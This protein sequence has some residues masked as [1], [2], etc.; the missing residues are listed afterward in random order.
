MNKLDKMSSKKLISP[1]IIMSS[2]S[3][4]GKTTLIRKLLIDFPTIKLSVSVTTRKP[5]KNEI[6]HIDYYFLSK[7]N[8][9]DLV[10]TGAFIEWVKLYRKT[11]YGT[12]K[13]E[14]EDKIKRG[15]I[16]LFDVD[17]DG[18]KRLASFFY[19]NCLS[20]FILPPSVEVLKQ[21]L[22]SRKTENEKELKERLTHAKKELTS[23]CFYD[24]IITNLHLEDTYKVLKQKIHSFLNHNHYNI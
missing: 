8:F 6:N 1:V 3:G 10:K 9:M 20:I 21:R 18:A 13:K 14:I 19:P 15:Y 16:C 5:R 4:G 22:I 23:H 11:Y 17:V 12:L 2:P 24:Y 7:S